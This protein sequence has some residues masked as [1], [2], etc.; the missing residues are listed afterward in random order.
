[1]KELAVRLHRNDDLAKSIARICKDYNTCVILSGV[2]CVF[3]AR[4]RLADGKSVFESKEEYEI[5]SLMGTVSCGNPHIHIS[6]SDKEGKTIGGHLLD[7]CLVN[8]TCELVIGVLEEYEST[9]PFDKD[10][11]WDE[12]EFKKV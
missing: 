6:L 11:G 10:T 3:E 7:G 8:T 2:G 5:V 12:I 9:R 1:M 4:F